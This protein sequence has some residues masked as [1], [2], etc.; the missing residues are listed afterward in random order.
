[1]RT[2]VHRGAGARHRRQG[3]PRAGAHRQAARASAPAATSPAWS[4]AC[5]RRPARSPSTAGSRQQR[6]H[7]T[8]SLLHTMP[9]PTIAAVNGAASGLG[10]DTALACDFIIASRCG[11]LHLVVHQPRHRPGRRRHVLPAAPGRPVQGQGADLHRPQGRAE[12]ALRLG[13]ADRMA[14]RRDAWSPTRRPGPPRLSKGSATALGP[15]Q[16]DP[17]PELRAAR[18]AGVRARQP[19]AGHLLHEHRAPRIGD[20]VPRQE[21]RTRSETTK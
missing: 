21:Q 19:G 18:G 1:M 15:G 3:H 12:E 20:G 14:G 4:G 2:R 8:Q 13:I 7:H 11:Q 6:V 9:K 10:A 16:V 17:Q 5:R